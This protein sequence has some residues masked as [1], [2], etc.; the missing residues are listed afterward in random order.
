LLR[1]RGRRWN[2]CRALANDDSAEPSVDLSN[3]RQRD[4]TGDKEIK[5]ELFEGERF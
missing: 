1:K 4:Q 3:R 5:R 2:Y